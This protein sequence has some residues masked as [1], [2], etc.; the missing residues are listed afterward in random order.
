MGG[1]RTLMRKREA[2]LFPLYD[3]FNRVNARIFET[4]AKWPAGSTSLAFASGWCYFGKRGEGLPVI[5]TKA[6]VVAE[7]GLFKKCRAQGWEGM[8][9]HAGAKARCG[10]WCDLPGF[11]HRAC[12]EETAW[13]AFGLGAQMYFLSS[14]HQNL[15]H[16][17]LQISSDN[18]ML[19]M[20]LPSGAAL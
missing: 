14:V 4:F 12:P 8:V 17:G 1:G 3:F 7:N 2:W 15:E 18:W 16:L 5:P 10:V 19:Q 9:V 6:F 11:A 20:F 13:A